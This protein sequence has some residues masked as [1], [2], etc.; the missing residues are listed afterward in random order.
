MK[1][2]QEGWHENHLDREDADGE[3]DDDPEEVV[4]GEDDGDGEGPEEDPGDHGDEGEGVPRS[5]SVEDRHIHFCWIILH[6]MEWARW[7]FFWDESFG[8][9]LINHFC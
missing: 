3:D 8:K 5:R 6:F 7:P 9:N 4:D 2:D 1:V